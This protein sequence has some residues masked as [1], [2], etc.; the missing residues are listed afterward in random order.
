MAKGAPDWVRQITV[1]AIVENTPVVP[2]PANERAAGGAGRYSGT[3]Q[4]YQTAVAWT[5]ATGYLG[6]LKEILIISDNIWVTL[7]CVASK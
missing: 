1:V 3:D 5:V 2:V 4:T 7:G 6:D